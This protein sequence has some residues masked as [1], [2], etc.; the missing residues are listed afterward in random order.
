MS[1]LRGSGFATIQFYAGQGI[2]GLQSLEKTALSP[3]GA[4]SSWQG[5]PLEH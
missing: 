5:H 3:A 1:F 2:N 4:G